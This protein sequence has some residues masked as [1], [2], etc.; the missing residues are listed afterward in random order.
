MSWLFHDRHE[1][2]SNGELQKQIKF[3]DETPRLGLIQ[4]IDESPNRI[5]LSDICAIAAQ[6]LTAQKRK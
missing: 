4:R 2:R 5:A 1:V 3:V 6:T